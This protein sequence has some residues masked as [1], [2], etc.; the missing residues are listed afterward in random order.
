MR[1]HWQQL[2]KLLRASRSQKESKGEFGVIFY[3]DSSTLTTFPSY[4]T[5]TNRFRITRPSDLRENRNLW[6]IKAF[7]FMEPCGMPNEFAELPWVNRRT[8][9]ILVGDPAAFQYGM[10]NIRQVSFVVIQ[11]RIAAS[12]WHVNVIWM[13]VNL[14]KLSYNR[15]DNRMFYS[16]L[17]RQPTCRPLLL[18]SKINYHRF[19]IDNLLLSMALY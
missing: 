4:F 2:Q 15:F 17:T 11:Y 10:V 14:F 12:K 1:F 5:Q 9:G 18:F 6:I 8:A 19:R 13:C 3:F 16:K 7:W